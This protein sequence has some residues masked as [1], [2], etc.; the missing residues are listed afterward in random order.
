MITSTQNA[1]LKLVR[2]LMGR[3]KE[4]LAAQAFL[5]EG[6]RLV[7]EALAANWPI[8]FVLYAEGLNERGQELIRKAEV[9]HIE[10]EQVS[11]PLLSSIS[12]TE[13]S[14]LI[15]AVLNYPVLP[16]PL[17]PDFVLIADQIRDPGN[18]GSLLRTAAAAGVQ[19]VIL[20]PETTDAFAPKVVRAG[21]G[22]HFRLPIHS[23]TWEEIG[24]ATKSLNIF[25]ADTEGAISCWE[26]DFKAPMALIIGGEAEGA[27]QAARTLAKQSVFIP[28]IG[29]TESLNAGTAGS[30]L[31]FEVVRQRNKQH[32]SL[33]PVLE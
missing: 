6:V 20:T 10:V 9:K 11:E 4:R 28:M 8:R 24:I 17:H 12:E 32:G 15:L 33:K 29:S 14:Q 18:L 27:S 13:N 23:L 3:P 22:A 7:E 21:M 31:I 19:A 25:L 5:V 2:S 16:I 26:T 1:K 30:I